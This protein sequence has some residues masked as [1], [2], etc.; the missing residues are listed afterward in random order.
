MA[1][2]AE[3]LSADGHRDLFL[4]ITLRLFS[5]ESKCDMQSYLFFP[6][7]RQRPSCQ[8]FSHFI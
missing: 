5:Q 4:G 8:T 6:D 1:V 3:I 7:M 2:T